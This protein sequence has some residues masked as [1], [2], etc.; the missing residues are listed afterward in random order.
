MIG[1]SMVDD[2]GEFTPRHKKSR[3]DA[4]QCGRSHDGFAFGLEGN[5]GGWLTI[6]DT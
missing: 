3:S 6:G 1:L 4:R 5:E 2:G